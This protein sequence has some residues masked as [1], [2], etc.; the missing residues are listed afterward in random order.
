MRSR[1]ISGIPERVRNWD[2]PGRLAGLVAAEGLTIPDRWLRL[3]AA[4]AGEPCEDL[5]G[6]LDACALR[7]FR[8]GGRREYAICER[9]EQANLRIEMD[10]AL[11]ANSVAAAREWLKVEAEANPR[12]D[13]FLDHWSDKRIHLRAVAQRMA[14]EE[15]A[16]ITRSGYRI[17]CGQGLY[18]VNEIEVGRPGSTIP[19]LVVYQS[20]HEEAS[21][22]SMPA[23]LLVLLP[24]FG[25]YNG[26]WGPASAVRSIRAYLV[27]TKALAST[28]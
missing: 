11:R 20:L 22:F 19:Q 2:G 3:T 21:G 17:E 7:F 13:R 14:K 9:L 23:P 12:D 16:K 8:S 25:T 10:P 1:D 15:G 28:I 26:V 24:G 18:L 6:E 4:L 27:A 5:R